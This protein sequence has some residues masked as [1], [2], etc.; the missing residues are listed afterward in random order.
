MLFDEQ[1]ANNLDMI[2]STLVALAAYVAIR[3]ALGW[4]KD[5]VA[6]RRLELAEQLLIKLYEAKGI[7]EGVRAQFQFVLQNGFE[8]EVEMNAFSVEMLVEEIQESVL[9]I[10]DAVNAVRAFETPSIVLYGDDIEANFYT[11]GE[12]RNSVRNLL[13]RARWPIKRA[14]HNTKDNF[15]APEHVP[16][17][18]AAVKE[19]LQGLLGTSG[20]GKK[21]G[22]MYRLHQSLGALEARCSDGLLDARTRGKKAKQY[23]DGLDEVVKRILSKHRN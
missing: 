14:L 4:R 22:A 11:I 20:D 13:S 10:D 23:P 2:E 9:R 7:V 12:T 16:S 19:N 18:R 8:H 1:F 21:D 3:V 17:V 15:I 5:F 6:R